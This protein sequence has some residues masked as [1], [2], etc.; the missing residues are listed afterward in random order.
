MRDSIRRFLLFFGVVTIG[1]LLIFV[2]PDMYG[3]EL[4]VVHIILAAF[5]FGVIILFLTGSLSLRNL[6]SRKAGSDEKKERKPLKKERRPEEKKKEPAH[7]EVPASPSFFQEQMPTFYSAYAKI[8]GI[9]SRP[10]GRRRSKKKPGAAITPA[11]TAEKHAR[12]ES[13][14]PFGDIS[15]D[16]LDEEGFDLSESGDAFSE[17]QESGGAGMQAD[18]GNIMEDA[19]AILAKEGALSDEDFEG[20]DFAPEIDLDSIDLDALEEDEDL[21]D[22]TYLD[23]RG[24]YEDGRDGE[25]DETPGGAGSHFPDEEEE[26]EEEFMFAGPAETIA[27]NVGFDAQSESGKTGSFFSSGSQGE[28]DLL[29]ELQKG[30]KNVKKK[31]DFSL[32]RDLKDVDVTARELEEELSSLV[33]ALGGKRRDDN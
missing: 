30:A 28:G 16:D 33:V 20:D 25:L 31:V 6:R 22:D 15:L 32:L 2:L 14:D 5:L 27:S 21:E 18:Y 8:K 10:G 12:T 4:P 24:E 26:E 29:S 19:A 9:F 13:S 11:G 3:I 7:P 17:L 23:D 1:L